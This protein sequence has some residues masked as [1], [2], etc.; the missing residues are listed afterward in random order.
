MASIYLKIVF[1]L[2]VI[3]CLSWPIHMKSISSS[4]QNDMASNNRTGTIDMRPKYGGGF[5][6]M[7]QITNWFGGF[8]GGGASAAPFI[9]CSCC[10][11]WLWFLV[12][13]FGR[14]QANCLILF[15][16]AEMQISNHELLGKWIESKRNKFQLYRHSNEFFSYFLLKSEVGRHNQ[17]NI[18][19]WHD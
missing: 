3:C 19:G 11:F 10:K 15:Q 6:Q 7:S 2:I 17:M 12:F 18:R 14:I 9:R 5:R 1:I 16:L 4:E 13:D 8:F